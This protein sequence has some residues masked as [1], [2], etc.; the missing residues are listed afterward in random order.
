MIKDRNV[1]GVGNVPCSR[2]I[3]C[4]FT[5]AA[6]DEGYEEPGSQET[7]HDD[8]H[9]AADAEEHEEGVAG[10]LGGDVGV[11]VEVCF[12]GG[13]AGEE[14]VVGVHN[15]KIHCCDLS[16]RTRD[17]PLCSLGM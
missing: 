6:Q 16:G 7:G 11:E 9:E 2:I 10:C 13:V 1:W 14:M 4:C 3:P 5:H 12:P 15:L 17:V 8:V